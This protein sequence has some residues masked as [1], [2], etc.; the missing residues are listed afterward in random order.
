MTYEREG[1]LLP[2]ATE[3]PIDYDLS[4]SL[5][6][7][8]GGAAETY[9]DLALTSEKKSAAFEAWHSGQNA[10]LTANHLDETD[11]DVKLASLKQW[12]T[13]LLAREDVD[14]LVKQLYRWKVNEHLANI[15]MLIASSNGDM[16]GFKRWNEF[17]YGKPDEDI[18]RAALDWVAHDA[19]TMIA[20][21]DQSVAVVEAA[22]NVLTLLEGKRGYRQILAPDEETFEKVRQDHLSDRGYYGLLLAGVEIPAGKVNRE[23]GDPILQRVL[24]NI[25][26]SK[27]IVDAAG[28]SWSVSSRG[29]ERPAEYNILAKRFQ[30]LGLG[31]EIGTHELERTNG[32]RGPLA[33]AVDGLD[34]YESGNEGRAVIREEVPYASFDEFGKIVRWRDIMRRHIAISFASGVGA[35]RPATSIE[36]YDFV[37]AIDMMY[38]TKVTPN[39]PE[40]T[41]TG[42]QDKTDSLLERVLKG[43]NGEGGAYLKDI[44]YLEGH[45]AN[46][47]TASLEGP[48]AISNGDLGKF[49]INNPRHIA[50][51]QKIGLLPEN[52]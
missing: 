22:Q 41:L 13:D 48:G 42:A 21:P 52:N 8:L 19:E 37:N 49:D 51:L 50:A 40:A 35:D 16:A 12:K 18:Y 43:T 15:N 14:S 24:D 47:L 17:I 30:G 5:K 28:A 23:M 29:V 44:V 38:Q 10:D 45:V 34:R 26:S 20:V 27:P 46:W 2:E 9:K 7:A 39:D 32:A 6:A 33:L 3:L 31:H 36:T 4:E 11:L 25:G 1:L